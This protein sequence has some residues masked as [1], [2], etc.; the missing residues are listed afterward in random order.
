MSTESATAHVR[1]RLEMDDKALR[2]NIIDELDFE[3][4]I[5]AAN[6]G[7]AVGKGVVTLTG[8]VE[9]YAEK[10]A[11][12]RAVERVRGVRAVAQEIEVRYAG[13]QRRA[14][15]EIAQRSLDII[16]WSVQVPSDSIKVEVENGWITLKGTVEWQYQKRAAESAVRRLSGVRGVSNLIEIK[17]QLA[18]SD[19]RQKIMNALKRNAEVEAD[20][21]RV[22]VDNDKVILEGTVRARY[23]RN[24]AERAAWSAPGIKDV[25]DRL[26]IG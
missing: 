7:V 3:P 13:H 10:I 25:E 18:A 14:D 4:S 21:I 8:H 15:D 20:N 26:S 6:I 12:E 22:V 24:L 16:N 5:N 17:P 23:E 1:R 11:A 19:V 2:Q 9:S